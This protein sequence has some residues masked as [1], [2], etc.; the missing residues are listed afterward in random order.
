MSERDQSKWTLYAAFAANA[1]IAI[2]KF[3]AAVISGSA[4]MFAEGLHSVV[5]TGDTVLLVVGTRLSRRPPTRTHPFGH[6]QEV[7]FWTIIVAMSVFG[8]GGCLSVY[9]GIHHLGATQLPE[10]LTWSYI[11]LA[12]SFVFEGTSWV[13]SL[14]S[15]RG[16]IRR[17]GLWRT[18][19]RSKD[20]TRVAVILEDSAALI[21]ILI[22]AAG[23]TLTLVTGRAIFDAIAS[24][25]IGTLLVTIGV[26]LGLETRSLLVG[27]SATPETVASIR[28]LACAQP[29]VKSAKPRTIH[30][31]PETIFVDLELD[32]DPAT[33]LREAMRAIEIAVREKHPDVGEVAFQLAVA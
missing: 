28:S 11:V 27:E 9:R 21:G 26:I 5:D 8:M 1:S 23:L 12:V 10:A 13:I 17:R 31:G 18:I 2:V 22:A 20:S 33:D 4:A 3:V 24:I 7:Y 19:E 6:G 30:L 16:S 15:V 25:L 32:I 29:G 14:R